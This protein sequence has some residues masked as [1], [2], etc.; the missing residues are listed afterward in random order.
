M[1]PEPPANSASHRSVNLLLIKPLAD[2]KQKTLEMFNCPIFSSR[3]RKT[4]GLL[5]APLTY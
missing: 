1:I 3:L 2:S 5:D 4:I